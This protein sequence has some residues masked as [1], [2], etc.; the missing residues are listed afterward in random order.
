MKTNK[1]D[2]QATQPARGISEVDRWSFSFSRSWVTRAYRSCLFRICF[3]KKFAVA[4]RASTIWKDASSR[5]LGTG[6]ARDR[7][8]IT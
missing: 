3:L 1:P 5:A 4:R 2:K 7:D 6:I 8:T